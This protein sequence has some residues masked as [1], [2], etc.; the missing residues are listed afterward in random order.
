VH[1]TLGQDPPGGSREEP[2][3]K[4][5]EPAS[6]EPA[7]KE[8][9]AKQPG[10]KE[11][12]PKMKKPSSEEKASKEKEPSSHEPTAEEKASK[13]KTPASEEKEPSAKGENPGAGAGTLVLGTTSTQQIVQLKL[14]A[15]QQ[16]LAHVGE[17][18]PVTL[19]GGEVV[20]GRITDVG[21]VASEAKESEKPNGG[22]K[23]SGEGESATIPVTLALDHRV[24]RLDEAPVSVELVKSIRHGVLTVPATA[25]I[26]TAGGGYAVEALEG[27]RR[28]VLGVT[29]GMF[30][31][32]YVQVEGAGLREGLSVIESQ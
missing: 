15:E 21:T 26:A 16:R 19:P 10:S 27:V 29:P 9:A 32:G 17:S 2:A 5:K 25:L 22:E 4:E 24:T 3:A 13:E 1:V 8:P 18:A 7:S 12:H 6:K 31:S 30:A 28:V 11:K 23:P 14:K 20:H